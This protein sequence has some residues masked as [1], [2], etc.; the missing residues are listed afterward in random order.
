MLFE[1][2]F[3]GLQDEYYL[4]NSL[5]NKCH[6]RKKTAH[7]LTAE[8]VSLIRLPTTLLFFASFKADLNREKYYAIENPSFLSL[9]PL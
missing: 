2:S 6:K 3:A 7:L 9:L 1:I 4:K 5:M 8:T